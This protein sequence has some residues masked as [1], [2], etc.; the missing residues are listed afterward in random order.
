MEVGMGVRGEGGVQVHAQ[1]CLVYG[2]SVLST[3]ARSRVTSAKS[4]LLRKGRRVGLGSG[5]GRRRSHG[6]YGL[7]RVDVGARH[8]ARNVALVVGRLSAKGATAPHRHIAVVGRGGHIA[9]DVAVV[10][11]ARHVA[12]VLQGLP[13]EARHVAA[14][15]VAAALAAALCAP[16]HAPRVAQRRLTAIRKD[17]GALDVCI[18]SSRRRLGLPRGSRFVHVK[19]G[20]K[21][22]LKSSPIRLRGRKRLARDGLGPI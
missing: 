10:R 4:T 21:I 14:R 6:R 20:W 18:M 9:E 2:L 17:A 8:G 3:T 13:L 5:G 16:S 19:V 15:V 1:G 7:G 22:R 12:G 11:R